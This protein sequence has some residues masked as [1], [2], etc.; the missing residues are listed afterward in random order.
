MAVE[1]FIRRWRERIQVAATRATARI[2]LAAPAPSPGEGGAA[3]R[4]WE[5]RDD[6]ARARAGFHISALSPDH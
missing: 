5:Y 1:A 3:L 4:I 6:D 2:A